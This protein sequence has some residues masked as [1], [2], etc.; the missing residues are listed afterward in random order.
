MN[1][2]L[3]LRRNKE[4]K[5]VRG[6]SVCPSQ[7]GGG[8]MENGQGYAGGNQTFAAGALSKH[9]MNNADFDRIGGR[10]HLLNI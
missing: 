3:I 2:G 5:H 4:R 1:V 8:S 7:P 6:M 10:R 9:G